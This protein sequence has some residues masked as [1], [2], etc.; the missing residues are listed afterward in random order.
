MKNLKSLLFIFL[1]GIVC[2]PTKA[3]CKG[4]ARDTGRELLNGYSI[5]DNYNSA[6]LTQGETAEMYK[7]V[8]EDRDYRIVVK[9][10]ET[11]P[12]I[13]YQVTNASG[14]I[15]FDNRYSNLTYLWD[16]TP[17]V[18]QQLKIGVT[19]PWA[20]KG[21]PQ[22]GC[23][24]ILFGYKYHNQVKLQTSNTMSKITA[25]ELA[26]LKAKYK[27]IKVLTVIVEPEVKDEEG[28]VIKEAESYEFAARR[29]DRSHISIL[30]KHAKAEEL[31]QFSEK[32]VKNLIV[33]GD[34]EALEDG[35]VYMGVV[36]QLQGLIVPAASFLKNA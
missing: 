10:S 27:N 11:L 9:G 33:G 25:Q 26:D 16:Y 19:V 36:S 6:I 18:T 1:L 14:C 5:D 2:I 4:F 8:I 7:T 3:Q 22:S 15:L 20:D 30:L 21:S 24:A 29:P 35:T 34:M 32:A 13:E 31:D 17:T 28:N 12:P 23:V